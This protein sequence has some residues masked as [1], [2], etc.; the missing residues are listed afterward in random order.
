MA[1]AVRLPLASMRADLIVSCA[2]LGSISVAAE[3]LAA[4]LH[5]EIDTL[6]TGL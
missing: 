3:V 6:G 5:E 4:C 2:G 1:S